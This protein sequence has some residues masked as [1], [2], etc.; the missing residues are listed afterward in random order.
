MPETI[1]I[2]TTNVATWTA[3]TMNF[4]DIST[5]GT[6]LNLTDDSEANITS[7]FPFTFFGATS[8]D[9]RVGNNG[10]ILFGV[11]TGDL[12]VTNAALPAAS[13]LPAPAILPF[14]DD[15]DDETGNVFWQV[16]GTSP[17]RK[18][19]V[20]WHNRPHYNGVGAVTFE[21]ILYETSNAIEFLYLDTDFGNPLY[22]HGISATS[23]LQEST[24]SAVQ[25]S[26][27]QAVLLN[28][29]TIRFEPTAYTPVVTMA[30][31]ASATDSATVTAL[32][33]NI[34]V[35]P[36]SLS[37]TQATNTTITQTLNISNTGAGPADLG[38][39]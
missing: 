17:N 14:W 25:Y 13:G 26:F 3:T 18:L 32:F 16:Q 27:N 19:I 23:G 22:N 29:M 37:S 31:T 20:Q 8:S 33:P 35:A 36:L 10:G 28:S 5:T 11:T 2:D 39:R 24:S 30:P 34:D 12:G 4:I 9:L 6:A 38:D 21:V 1:N 7:P 15:F